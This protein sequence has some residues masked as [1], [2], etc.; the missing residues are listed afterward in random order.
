[1]T[2]QLKCP[3]CG[4]H[5]IT[6][7][8]KA[9]VYHYLTNP[10]HNHLGDVEC[11]YEDTVIG[12]EYTKCYFCEHCGCE[13]ENIEDFVMK[14]QKLVYQC[15]HCGSCELTVCELREVW[16][17]C[18]PHFDLNVEHNNIAPCY[19][20]GDTK[21]GC[22]DGEHHSTLKYACAKCHHEWLTTK[23]MYEDGAL[24]KEK[25]NDAYAREL[26]SDEFNAVWQNA[27][28]AV[29][30]DC[31]YNIIND[32]DAGDGKIYTALVEPNSPHLEIAYLI[33]RHVEEGAVEF[34]P[35][36]QSYYFKE[37]TDCTFIPKFKLV[38]VTTPV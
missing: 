25:V 15:P 13:S 32:Y 14:T 34:N 4:S 29:I 1:M 26:T 16:Y 12:D 21:S 6:E 10:K 36:T 9:C 33:P 2:L 18:E 22:G 37:Q 23:E 7:V 28:A 20:L 8:T 11:D 27:Y 38:T 19:V 5:K 3:N 24:T 35:K 30:D 17:D 31:I